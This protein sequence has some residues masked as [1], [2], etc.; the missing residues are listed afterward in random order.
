LRA[1]VVKSGWSVAVGAA[2]LLAL[3]AGPASATEVDLATLP[4][5]QPNLCLT[6][7]TVAAPDPGDPAL[8]VFGA[9][10]LANGRVWDGTLA[11]LDSD[12]DGCLNGVEV[13][14]ADGDGEADGNVD[15]QAGNPGVQDD[16]AAGLADEKTW[17]ALK[18]LFDGRR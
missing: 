7:H 14:D 13:G 3:A 16:C 15:E 5:A 11:Q 8:N 1:T 9:D 12:Q 17:S 10:F 2:V 18:A 4:V 6:C